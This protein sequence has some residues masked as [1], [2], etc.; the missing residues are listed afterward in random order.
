M[1]EI[2]DGWAVP[3]VEVFAADLAPV[4]A[5]TGPGDDDEPPVAPVDAKRRRK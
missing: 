2:I 3:D 1:Q 4:R 5:A